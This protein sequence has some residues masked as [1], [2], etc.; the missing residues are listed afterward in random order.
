MKELIKKSEIFIPD[1]DGN[2][3]VSPEAALKIREVHVNFKE[4]EK[5]Y[6]KMKD[7]VLKGMEEFGIKKVDTEDVLITYV[8]EGEQIKMDNDRLWKEH[9]DIAFECQKVVPVKSSIRITAR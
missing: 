1:E 2:M 4:L 3:I 9:K 8:E 5:Q 6:K 7:V